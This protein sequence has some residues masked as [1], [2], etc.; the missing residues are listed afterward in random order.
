MRLTSKLFRITESNHRAARHTI[1]RVSTTPYVEDLERFRLALECKQQLAA[2]RG[3]QI[4]LLE[5][6][7]LAEDDHEEIL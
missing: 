6:M 2:P 1:T 4:L 3:E 5:L 7:L